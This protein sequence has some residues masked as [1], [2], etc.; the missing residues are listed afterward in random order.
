MEQGKVAEKACEVKDLV[1]RL[2]REYMGLDCK[3][4]TMRDVLRDLSTSTRELCDMVSGPVEA[5]KF[6]DDELRDL[7]NMASFA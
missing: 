7:Y 6:S 2:R 5:E 3:T 4:E 1:A